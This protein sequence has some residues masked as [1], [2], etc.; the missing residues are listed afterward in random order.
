MSVLR[1]LIS[2][3]RRDD[4]GQ[5]LAEYALILALIAIIAIVAHNFLGG[6]VSTNLSMV[7]ASI[8]ATTIDSRRGRAHRQVAR[9]LTHQAVRT[10]DDRT[11]RA[12]DTPSA[13]HTVDLPANVPGKSSKGSILGNG[14]L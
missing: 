3:I 6:L 13:N 7:G 14:I 12:I 10:R 11:V 9:P 5:G 8:S 1:A 2:S 4:R